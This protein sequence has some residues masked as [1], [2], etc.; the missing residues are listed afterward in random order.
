MRVNYDEIRFKGTWTLPKELQDSITVQL[1]KSL[2][3]DGYSV[4]VL[5]DL[6]DDA[7]NSKVVDLEDTVN[8]QFIVRLYNLRQHEPIDYCYSGTTGNSNNDQFAPLTIDDALARFEHLLSVE[9]IVDAY[10]YA[11][12]LATLD[13]TDF[14]AIAEAIE[15]D[16]D[17]EHMA[18]ALTDKYCKGYNF[19]KIVAKMDKEV[20]AKIYNKYY[21]TLS[22]SVLLA[23]YYS[24]H[25]DFVAVP[26]G[27]I[28]LYDKA[29]EI[30][31][32][33]DLALSV[34]DVRDFMT[35]GD[36]SVMPT[37]EELAEQILEYN[38]F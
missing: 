10:E 34:K 9:R 13:D 1:E 36:N 27:T 31:N 18:S 12:D 3:L 24:H 4:S 28:E 11:I 21:N 15:L 19:D 38:G 6:V 23:I 29:T 30:V 26:Y 17:M 2:L 14:L 37:A 35:N 5:G 33:K 20:L 7:I 32:S 16:I 25:S 22:D 8:V